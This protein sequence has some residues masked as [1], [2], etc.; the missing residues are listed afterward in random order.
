MQVVTNLISGVSIPKMVKVRQ[1]FDDTHISD[2]NI[3]HLVREQLD[4]PEILG[5]IKSGMNVAITCGS[6]G[7]KNYALMAKTIVNLVKEHGGIPFIVAAMGSHG[8]A[9]SAGQRQILADYGITEETM[10]CQIKSDM[11]T[12]KIGHCDKFDT[13]VRIDKNAANAD[14]II[15]F[16]R[17]KIHTSFHGSYESGLM[18]MMAIGLGKQH[19]AN[20]IHAVKP[21]LMDQVVEMHGKICLENAPVIGGLGVIENAFDDTWKIIGLTPNEIVKEEP[22]LL[23][24]AKHQFATLL[25]DSC[26]VLVVDKIGKNISGDGMDPNVTGRFATNIHGGIQVDKIVVLDLT[27]ETHGNAQGIGNAEVTTRRLERKMRREMTYP[28]AVTNKFLGLDKMPMVMDND[29]EAL[30]LALKACYTE[31]TETLRVIHIQDT[32]HLEYIEI[33]ESLLAE[34]K[35]NSK[36][37]I[38]SSPFDWAFNKFGNLW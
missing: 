22:K 26:D 38:L 32:S 17:I 29:K 34:A 30:Q 3:E 10:K 15:V 7:I 19:G 6:R 4:K 31:R 14:A 35:E 12:V 37:E 8:G 27:D 1:K 33:S 21:D 5:K 25:F 23:I 9:T 13:D 16:N 18:K 24:E 28:T 20:I 2:N 36:I 11:D